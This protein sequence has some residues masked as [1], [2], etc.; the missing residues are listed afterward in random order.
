VDALVDAG[1]TVG[2][3]TNKPEPT[4]VRLVRHFFGDKMTFVRGGRAGAVL[5]PDPTDA[6]DALSASCGVPGG[7][8]FVGDTSVDIRTARNMSAA[9]SIGV[10]WGFRTREELEGESP[11]L[12]VKEAHEILDAVLSYEEN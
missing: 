9:L 10:L 4:A 12:L 7:C 6:L 5:K 1:I 2:V 8:A 11:D 3:V